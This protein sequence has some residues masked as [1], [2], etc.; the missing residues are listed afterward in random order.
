MRVEPSESLSKS[1]L[2]YQWIRDKI[3]SREFEAGHRLVLSSIAE[4]LDV[5]AVPVREAIR[6]LEAE[7][8]VTYERN[9]G[10]RVTTLNRDSYFETME[11]VAILEAHATALSV[12]H[13]SSAEVAKARELN[14]KMI[15]LLG[16]FDPQEFTALNQKF[17]GTLFAR[18]P[19]SQLVELLLNEWDRLDRFRDS[20]F[21]YVPYRAQTSVEEHEQLI[22]LIE[23]KADPDYIELKARQHRLTTSARYREQITKEGTHQ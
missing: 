23:A 10:A 11:T 5:S 9:V 15:A 19:N 21:K 1:A 8:L 13:L 12:P 22:Q 14:E 3:R 4:E 6:Q 20:T 17:H 2:T 16:D 18:C 7:G